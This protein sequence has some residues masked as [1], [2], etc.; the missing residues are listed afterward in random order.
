MSSVSSY[1]KTEESAIIVWPSPAVLG[2]SKGILKMQSSND[3]PRQHNVEF[4]ISQ[5]EKQN[6][7]FLKM[8]ENCMFGT[9]FCI[10]KRV[11]CWPYV[12]VA[13]FSIG[14]NDFGQTVNLRL[15]IYFH[16]YII[17]NENALFFA[18]GISIF[19]P[20]CVV[21][22][23]STQIRRSVIQLFV[24]FLSIDG[25]MLTSFSYKMSLNSDK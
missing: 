25:T 10:G 22:G 15:T 4:C 7:T 14:C 11:Y 2:T 20:F 17:F 3:S 21:L 19:M 12:F 1:G 24:V 8:H 9:L 18:K 5:G 13:L 16:K 6:S 23:I